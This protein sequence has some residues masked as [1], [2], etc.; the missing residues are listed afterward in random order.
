M[1][2]GLVFALCVDVDADRESEFNEW[3]DKDHLPAVVRCPGVLSGRRFTAERVGRGQSD[4]ARYWAFYEVV[5]EEAMHSPEI[6]EL[7]EEGF[8]PFSDAV[9]NVKRYWFRQRLA[10]F[11]AAG[12]DAGVS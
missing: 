8:G 3:Y 2:G 12:S 7:A 6:L 11:S 5:S 9:R 4:I 10:E 1:T